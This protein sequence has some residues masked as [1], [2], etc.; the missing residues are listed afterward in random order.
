MFPDYR[1]EL[2]PAKDVKS[3]PGRNGGEQVIGL[4]DE[5]YQ[6]RADLRAP[7]LT[8]LERLRAYFSDR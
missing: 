1:F 7:T 4:L 5:N 6:M 8:V 2:I 3:K